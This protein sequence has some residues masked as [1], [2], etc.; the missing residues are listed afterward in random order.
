MN[1]FQNLSVA[2]EQFIHMYPCDI[3]IYIGVCRGNT[4]FSEDSI[5]CRFQFSNEGSLRRLKAFKKDFP[6]T[7]ILN[8]RIQREFLEAKQL[9]SLG[10]QSK[11]LSQQY[12][13]IRLQ[14]DQEERLNLYFSEHVLLEYEETLRFYQQRKQQDF[15]S[16]ALNPI[17]KHMVKRMTVR[18]SMASKSNVIYI[19]DNYQ[20]AS[21][22]WKEQQFGYYYQE[23]EQKVDSEDLLL[24]LELIRSF[25]NCNL[26]RNPHYEYKMDSRGNTLSLHIQCDSG[27]IIE[28]IGDS[29]IHS[30]EKA[31]I[32]DDLWKV[33][34]QKIEKM[35]KQKGI[36]ER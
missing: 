26:N 28:I 32:I 23:K 14:N 36:K 33:M 6:N 9:I 10:D 11:K 29:L 27:E 8:Q 20:Y 25:I 7:F 24:I 17:E 4:L 34:H 21:S 1:Q 13:G 31:A 5:C 19:R 22:L 15:L 35:P 12:Q 18:P 16:Y 3:N 2:V 30:L